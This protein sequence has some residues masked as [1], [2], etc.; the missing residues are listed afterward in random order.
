V[1]IVLAVL[2]FLPLSVLA[3]VITIDFVRVLHGNTEEA[4]YFYENNWRN[5][6]IAA[7]EKGIIS[8]Y[9]LLVRTS[10][11]GQTDILLIT[12]FASPEQYELREE[13]FLL[14]MRDVAESGPALLN[15]KP[16]SEFREIVDRAIYTSVA[17]PPEG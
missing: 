14:V 16:P 1:R 11:K 2:V 5:F 7:V 6:R 3:E 13:N 12:V 17:T 4:V 10:E 8:S 9:D 15:D